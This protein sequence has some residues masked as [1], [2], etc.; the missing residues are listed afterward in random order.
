MSFSPKN[1][2]SLFLTDFTQ[3]PSKTWLKKGEN[4]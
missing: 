3:I 1:N 4:C 2:F